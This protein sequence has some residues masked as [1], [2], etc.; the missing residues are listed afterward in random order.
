MDGKI[1]VFSCTG[2]IQLKKNQIGHQQQRRT[3]RLRP[4]NFVKTY[5]DYLC[6]KHQNQAGHKRS[7]PGLLKLF[8]SAIRFKPAAN[9]GTFSKFAGHLDEISIY[10]PKFGVL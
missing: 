3:I 8:C 1:C 5:F 10:V 7:R 2:C 4:N 9:F 6:R